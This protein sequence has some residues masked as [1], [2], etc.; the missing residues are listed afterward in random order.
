MTTN[1]IKEE[2]VAQKQS[3]LKGNLYH[4]SQIIFS[5]NSNK[6]EGSRLTEDQTE[7]IFSISPF[8]SKDEELIESNDEKEAK[9]HF[10]L[11]DYILDNAEKL[12]T[13]EMI[14]ELHKIL[15]RN[16]IDEDNPKYNIEGFKILPNMIG[17]INTINT[18]S[19]KDVE[20]ELTKLLDNYN[21]KAIITMEDIIDFHFKFE[22]IHPFGDGNGRIGR[23]IMFKECLKNNIIPFI[24][25]DND[26]PHYL[27]G[28]REY[29]NNKT[30]LT[31]TCLNAQDNYKKIC[32]QLLE[33]KIE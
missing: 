17:M 20:K 5:Y 22:C 12:L 10:K 16:T 24:I 29:K 1:K 30:Y 18:T 19:P 6:M 7:A 4:Y 11:F 23:I 8:L 25:L 2:L 15:K 33:S 13:K 31:D 27:R 14:I 28:L 32:N 3:N 9:N 21:K 26:K